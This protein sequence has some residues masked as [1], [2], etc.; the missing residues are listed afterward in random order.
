MLKQAW[1]PPEHHYTYGENWAEKIF[2]G[3]PPDRR[4]IRWTWEGVPGSLNP[5]DEFTITING[6]LDFKP[7]GAERGANNSAFVG[8]EGLVAI[9]EE[10]AYFYQGASRIGT[11]KYQ[12]PRGAKKVVIT[13][14][15]DNNQGHFVRHC[16]G[17]CSQ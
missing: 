14:S 4:R 8:A 12:V 9:K 10:N 3:D 17:Q 7:A 6:D 2:I 16:Y 13:L 1:G 15:A 5:G 11:Y